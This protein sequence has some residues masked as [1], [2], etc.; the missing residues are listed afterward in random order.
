VSIEGIF[1]ALNEAEK[2]KCIGAMV[3][4]I[5]NQYKVAWYLNESRNPFLK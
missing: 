4:K 3:F 5:T 1:K 2:W